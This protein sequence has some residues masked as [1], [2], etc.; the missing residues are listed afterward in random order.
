MCFLPLIDKILD[1]RCP[2]SSSV[3]HGLVP[4][5]ALLSHL[6]AQRLRQP[7]D[8]RGPDAEQTHADRHQ[9]LPAV[10][11]GQRPHDGH[12]LH[13]LH[14]HPQHP[15][16]LHLRRLHVQDRHLLYG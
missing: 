5:P 15:G 8:H 12:L 2:L 10:A 1:K 16:G 7:A 3:R 4:H 11:G 13:A 6:P 9:L 14:P